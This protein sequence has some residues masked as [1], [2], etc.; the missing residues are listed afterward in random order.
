M[1]GL[2]CT[3]MEQNAGYRPIDLADVIIVACSIA[4]D[5]GAVVRISL[6]S[7]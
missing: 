4:S 3:V 6:K 7:G 2:A 1:N 5:S